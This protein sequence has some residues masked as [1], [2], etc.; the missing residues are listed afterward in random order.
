MS[1]STADG[2]TVVTGGYVVSVTGEE[3]P[4]GH[5]L[6]ADG[7]IRAVR[8][9]PAPAGEPG[10][11]IDATG[12]LVT[13]GLV[14]AHHHLYQWAF[15]G[16]AVDA[17]LF[18]WL[19][20]MYPAWARIDADVAHAAATAGLS[21]LASTGC[22]LSGDHHYLFPAGAGD[23]FA[24]TVAAAGE[25]GLRFQP[26]RGS[27]DR[28]ASA[29]GLPPDEIVED[30]DAA[31]AATAAAVEKYHDPAPDSMIRV[32]V[33]PCAPFVVSTDLMRGTAELARRYGVRLHTHL[34]ET[35]D[36]L[37]QCR[38]EH[39]CTPVEY[40]D[41]LGWLGSDVWVA[42]AVHLSGRDVGRL[43]ATG[44]ACAHCPSSNGR[45]GS[46]VSPVRD[47]LSAGVP[48]G[49]GVDGPASNEDGGLVTE[50]RQAVLTARARDGAAALG[51]RD[52]LRMATLGGARC[53]GRDGELGSLEP[54]KLADIAVWR[55]D[56]PDHADIA[57][58]VAALVFGPPPPVDTLLVGGRAVVSGGVLRTVSLADAGR[59]LAA[60]ARR[61]R[62]ARR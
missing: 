13:P 56:G 45:L 8:P 21:R 12:C 34:A 51:V 19:A 28:G 29:G 22:T 53:L 61:M 30:T 3:Y 14:N 40:L 2:R 7:R 54:G 44:T 37:R 6:V 5:V 15:R 55:L 60:Q 11:R 17:S 31:L 16:R 58:P 49:L 25:V 42:H 47:L 1:G 24:A 36:E 26:T 27:M 48:V 57:D 50:A 38:A 62:S 52:A 18:D 32:G 23:V 4:V 46:G 39:G 9:G 20:D 35:A 33:A 41:R 10:R 43:A 59:R